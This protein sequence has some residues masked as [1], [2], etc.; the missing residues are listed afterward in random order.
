MLFIIIHGFIYNAKTGFPCLGVSDA[1]FHDVDTQDG[2]EE[3]ER[4]SSNVDAISG[5]RMEVHD[6]ESDMPY[7][8]ENLPMGH[9]S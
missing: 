5:L 4:I 9:V 1:F 8:L 7:T 6:V 3:F 2:R